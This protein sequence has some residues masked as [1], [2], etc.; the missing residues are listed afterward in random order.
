[1]EFRKS[2]P[3]CGWL[4]RC[5][6]GCRRPTVNELVV[7]VIKKNY[8]DSYRCACCQEC[9]SK[10]IQVLQKKNYQILYKIRFSTHTNCM[11]IKLC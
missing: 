8:Y 6:I 11:L 4:K 3:E 2:L 9:F 1:M 7:F 5:S 10:K